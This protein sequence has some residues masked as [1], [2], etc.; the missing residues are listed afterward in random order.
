MGYFILL[1]EEQDE[2]L[3]PEPETYTHTRLIS[4]PAS[5]PKVSKLIRAYSEYYANRYESDDVQP[6]FMVGLLRYLH[7]RIPLQLLN[8]RQL[9]LR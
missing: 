2:E 3:E 4:T 6:D 9:L 8:S 5:G 7:N 1:Y